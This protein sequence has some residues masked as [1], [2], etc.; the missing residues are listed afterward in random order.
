MSAPLSDQRRKGPVNALRRQLYGLVLLSTS[1]SAQAADEGWRHRLA[2]APSRIPVAETNDAPWSDNDVLLSRSA[3][4]ENHRWMAYGGMSA[5]N[6]HARTISLDF[7]YVPIGEL[8]FTAHF[9]GDDIDNLRKGLGVD[10][11]VPEVGYFHLNLYSGRDGPNRGKRWQVNP[12]GMNLP[13]SHDRLWSLG[14]T[15]DLAKPDRNS[16][17]QIMFIPQLILNVDQL[18]KVPGHMQMAMTYSR[19]N[20]PVSGLLQESGMTPQVAFKWTY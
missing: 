16:A 6:A 7:A 17:R 9:L 13:E 4:A 5:L 8:L 15:L 14:G 2:A 11:A 3:D 19:W 18:A 10:L 12:S 20:S 1:L